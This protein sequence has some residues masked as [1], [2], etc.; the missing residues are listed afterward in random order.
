MAADDP[1]HRLYPHCYHLPSSQ[2][3]QHH[4]HTINTNRLDLTLRAIKINTFLLKVN[5]NNTD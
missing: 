5:N 4:Q 3:I 1:V 2:S